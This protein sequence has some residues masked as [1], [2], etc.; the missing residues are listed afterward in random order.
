M[1]ALLIQQMLHLNKSETW[2]IAQLVQWLGCNHEE[3]CSIARTHGKKCQAW[4]CV[5]VMLALG[6]Q[7]EVG[8]WGLLASQSSIIAELQ[9][10]CLKEKKVDGVLEE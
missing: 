3:L 7:R 10:L 2:E 6:R 5:L 9:C 8:P 4:W 1:I